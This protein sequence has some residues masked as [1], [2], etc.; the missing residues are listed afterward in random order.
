EVLKGRL[1]A[2]RAQTA[3]LVDHYASKGMLMTVNG[4]ASIDAVT[5][6]IAAHLEPLKP[7]RAKPSRRKSKALKPGRRTAALS[8]A[9][10][11]IAT[12][13]TPKTRPGKVKNRPRRRLTTAQ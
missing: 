5:A 9:R 2:Y 6:A 3:P 13:K 8:R 7:R 10:R 11:K 12:V 4:M 1:L